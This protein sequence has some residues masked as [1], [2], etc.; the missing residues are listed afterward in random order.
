VDGR[1]DIYS[2]GIVLYEMLTG[3]VPFDDPNPVTITYK[4]VREDP[5]PPSVV[6]P[7]IPATLE[8]IVMKAM[9]KNPA[10]RFQNAQEMKADLLRFLEGMPVSATPFLPEAAYGG[11]TAAVPAAG[12]SRKWPWIVGG[13]VA[14]L[15]VTGIILALVLGAEEARSRCRTCRG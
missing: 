12:A 10:N 7:E 4:Q 5:M 14:A 8:A 6:D 9:S 13:V 11:A 1:S 2:L 15:I 3:Q